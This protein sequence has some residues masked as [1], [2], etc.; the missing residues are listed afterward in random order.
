LSALD[1]EEDA[2]VE[3]HVRA[4]AVALNVFSRRPDHPGAAHY[5][6]HAFDTPDL[7]ALALPAARRDAATAPEAHHARHMPSHI[8]SRLGMWK[9]ALA[10]NESAWQASDAWTKRAGL[11]IDKR[12]YH[13]LNWIVEIN[14]E[15]GKRNAAEAAM[16][17][18]M[19]SAAVA[20]LGKAHRHYA[21]Q[22]PSYLERTHDWAG[23][24]TYA[25]R[26]QKLLDSKPPAVREPI[27][28][29]LFLAAVEA[30]EQDEGRLPV[31]LM[32]WLELHSARISRGSPGAAD[33]RV[34]VEGLRE[35]SRVLAGVRGVEAGRHPF[36]SAPKSVPG[37]TS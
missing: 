31:L 33:P 30:L 18:F 22:V 28:D 4:G 19:E 3:P 15:L 34:P 1:L 6:I 26:L 35:V 32:R 20:T 29:A 9:D 17:T 8:F 24:E 36:S 12:D 37:A 21:T 25:A 7:A 27:A 23:V 14:F 11:P 13:S 5:I 16:K 2:Q 10:S